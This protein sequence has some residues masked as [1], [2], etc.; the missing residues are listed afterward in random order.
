M[1]ATV[2]RFLA[3][4]PDEG[5]AL[6]N[7]EREAGAPV[8]TAKLAL[9]RAVHNLRPVAEAEHSYGPPSSRCAP[10]GRGGQPGRLPGPA[11]DPRPS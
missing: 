6:P 3:D 2:T 1:A 8:I 11:T 4:L 9:A 5:G 7:P 10:G